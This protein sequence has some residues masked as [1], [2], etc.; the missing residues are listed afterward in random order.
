M[1]R[2]DALPCA[3]EAVFDS[4]LFVTLSTV[5][6]VIRPQVYLARTEHGSLRANGMPEIVTPLVTPAVLA[7][8]GRA[9]DLHW[10]GQRLRQQEPSIATPA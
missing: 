9:V 6:V 10:R 8:D 2:H 1:P 7:R 5:D 3:F 4:N